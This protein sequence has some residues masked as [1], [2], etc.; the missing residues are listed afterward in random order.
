MRLLRL[1]LVPL[2][3][4]FPSAALAQHPPHPR[5]HL[6]HE[7]GA[8]RQLAG[9]SSIVTYFGNLATASAAVKLDTLGIST[10]GRPFITAT[11]STPENIRNLET[12]RANQRRLAD[13]RLLSAE[14]ERGLITTQPGVVVISCSIHSTEIAASQMAME[15]AWRLATNDTLQEA[16]ARTVVVLIPSVNPD[17][18]D[19][20]VDFY[21]QYLGTRWE[22]GF[23][24]W[25][26]HH[27]VGHDN[28]RDWFMVTQRETKLVTDLL[29]RSWFPQV[30]YDVHQMGN[31]GMRFF[32]P[33]FVDP[34]NPNV[35][36]MIVRGIDLIGMDMQYALEQHGKSG[37]GSGVVFDLW[38]HGGMRSTPTRH[39]MIGILSEAASVRIATP[40][41][42]DTSR[43]RGHARGL[44]RYERRMNF[45][46]PW[47][48]G[49]WRL[50]D[51][52]DYELIAAEAL[53]H[54]MSRRRADFVSSF[55]TLGRNQIRRGGSEAP[56]AFEIPWRQHD[57]GAM[58]EL[59]RVLRDGGVEL[60]ERAG[61]GAYVVRLDQPYRAHAKDLLEPQLFPAGD[62][63]Y[64]VAGWTLP[65][66]MGVRVVQ[67]DTPVTARLVAARAEIPI[68]HANCPRGAAGARG[69]LIADV[70]DTRSY[71]EVVRRLASRSGVRATTAVARGPGGRSWPA[72]SFVLDGPADSDFAR[73][74]A[75]ACERADRTPTTRTVAQHPR[76]ALYKPWT[77]NMD[78]GWTRWLFDQFG[79]RYTSLTDSAARAGR[80]RD[81]FDVLLVPNMSLREMRVGRP[82]TLVPPQYAGGLGDDG[83]QAIATFVRQGGTLLLLD[84]ASEFA[85]EVLR[86]PVQLIRPPRPQ[87]EEDRSDPGGLYAP[88]SVLRVL[89]N[90]SHPLMA[91][92]PDTA[93]VYFTNSV[94][95]DVAQ[96][97][98]VQVLAR[99]PTAGQDV[100][101]SGYIREPETIAGKAAAVTTQVGEGRVVM[102]G[103]RP[104]HRGQSWGTFRLLF[105]GLLNSGPAERR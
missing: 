29:Y 46:N 42:Q 101:M 91:G 57:E 9:W 39:N 76:V 55:V 23:L 65:M 70:R 45:P 74:L 99:Y 79:V 36:P 98:Q 67:V 31:E 81:Q 26:Y 19:M 30:L 87:S 80:L 68:R 5:T 84:G 78:E 7:V 33:P 61:G 50:R 15:L 89:V 20:V 37:V 25:L 95:F 82:D 73:G 60:H 49:T 10:L 102:F 28:N 58:R 16:L 13:P 66:Q 105:N 52:V 32:V 6:G 93:G 83:L 24:P 47:P 63:P 56:Y 97:A 92:M 2:L 43:L 1:A 27:Y 94:T 71:E 54:L 75:M 12:I 53:V 11:I 3:A 22:G 85:T 17:G 62:R 21:N 40:I 41:E 104:Q 96:E 100:L 69:E 88:G 35:D 38:W 72:G 8:D 14:E 86:V 59:I 18:I 4:A 51:I 77:A 90:T 48:G 103:F 34:I 64:D 44:P